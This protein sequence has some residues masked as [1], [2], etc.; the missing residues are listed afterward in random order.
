MIENQLPEKLI[1]GQWFTSDGPVTGADVAVVLT[2]VASG[3][4]P[5]RGIGWGGSDRRTDRA[6]QLLRRHGAV[7]FNKVS[8]KWEVAK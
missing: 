7:S 4:A 3:E 1:G 8:R 5:S 2:N 6:L